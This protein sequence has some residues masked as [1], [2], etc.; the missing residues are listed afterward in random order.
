MRSE[1][2][3]SQENNTHR[4]IESKLERWELLRLWESSFLNMWGLCKGWYSLFWNQIK[5]F[6][7]F[8]L[9]GCVHCVFLFHKNEQ[10]HRNW[11]K[12][13][14]TK[15]WRESDFACC[16]ANTGDALRPGKWRGGG[17]QSK[18]DLCFS[19]KGW[20]IDEKTFWSN[21]F[22]LRL[23]GLINVMRGLGLSLCLMKI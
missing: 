17:D 20:S 6:R 4:R 21:F 19:P 5:T 3:R 1:L 13:W 12:L 18:E 22:Q 9:P 14:V 11:T 7:I 10:L 16:G 15:H 2:L 8:L 23:T